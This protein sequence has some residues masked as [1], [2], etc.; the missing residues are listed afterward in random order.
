MKNKKILISIIIVLIILLI[1]GGVFAYIY[2]ATDLLKSDYELFSK[3]MKIASDSITEFFKD[4][5]M[6]NYLNKKQ[7]MPYENSGKINAKVE[8]DY[9]SIDVNLISFTGAVDNANKK[10]EQ[11]FK[12]NYSDTVSLPVEYVQDGDKYAIGSEEI[13]T[14]YLTIENNNLKQFATNLGIDSTDIPDKIEISEAQS[15]NYSVIMQRYFETIKDN[16]T[17]ENFFKD[18]SSE[19]AIYSVKIEG[20]QLKNLEKQL[21]NQLKNDEEI[22][23]MTGMEKEEYQTNIDDSM[24]EVDSQDYAS[25]YIQLYVYEAVNNVS[26]IVIDTDLM[27]VELASTTNQFAMRLIDKDTEET[28]L[29]QMDISVEKTATNDSS[30]YVI[31]ATIQGDEA[32]TLSMTIELTGL[33]TNNVTESYD[34][35]AKVENETVEGKFTNTI[36]FKDSVTTTTLTSDN[37]EILNTYSEED[38][39][40]LL[41]AL[42]MQIFTVN[43]QKLEAAGASNSG[44]S[45]LM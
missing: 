16:L 36:A 26:K 31:S 13:V 24:K 25:K 5:N 4:D 33:S 42:V 29:T 6:K 22:I 8:S 1:C 41:Q 32:I 12:I 39:A 30:K 18:T 45:G 2:F 23:Q 9:S 21:L 44:L 7:T 14:K 34:I 10:V 28:Q 17:E 43:N 3:N 40:E 15:T 19:Q 11:K 35:N 20:E 37:A 27:K 38:L